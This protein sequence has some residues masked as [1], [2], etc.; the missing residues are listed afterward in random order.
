MF[1]H[2]D[3]VPKEIQNANS[4]LQH[5]IKYYWTSHLLND[6]KSKR[7]R[8]LMRKRDKEFKHA[9]VGV[10]KITEI[11]NRSLTRNLI[12]RY[13]IAHEYWYRPLFIYLEH[14]IKKRLIPFIEEDQLG[15]YFVIWLDLASSHYAKSVS[16]YLKIKNIEIV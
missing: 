5:H 4:K 1:D 9:A 3:G 13:I 6:I 10:T 15:D 16:D 12:L 14:C 8:S 11:L 7:Y 2:K